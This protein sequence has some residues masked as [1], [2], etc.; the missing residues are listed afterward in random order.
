MLRDNYAED[1]VFAD[2]LPLIPGMD[3]VLAKVKSIWRMTNC[4]N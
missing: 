3:P 4:F 2:I 1:K